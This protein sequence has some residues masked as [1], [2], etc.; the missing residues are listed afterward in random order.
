MGYCGGEGWRY[1][2]RDE[3]TGH[4]MRGGTGFLRGRASGPLP[5]I[6]TVSMLGWSGRNFDGLLGACTMRRSVE[7]VADSDVWC[8][9]RIVAEVRDGKDRGSTQSVR[10][11]LS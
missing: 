4:Y 6:R 7:S 10:I 1:Q 9:E 3:Y 2:N 11:P 8:G 5:D